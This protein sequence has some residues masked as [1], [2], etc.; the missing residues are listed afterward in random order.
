[1][2]L[3][4]TY[5]SI[6]HQM[7]STPILS[8]RSW[9]RQLV[10]IDI[11]IQILDI[12]LFLELLWYNF[13]LLILLICLCCWEI[14]GYIFRRVSQ[15]LFILNFSYIASGQMLYCQDMFSLF[16]FSSLW[17]HMKKKREEISVDSMSSEW[18]AVSQMCISCR[19]CCLFYDNLMAWKQF[20]IYIQ[21]NYCNTMFE[22]FLSTQWIWGSLHLTSPCE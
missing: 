21:F 11:N 6:F 10:I 8:L 15:R 20:L 19:F 7:N 12:L 18:I 9:L 4:Q 16:L 3:D 1:M 5:T 22:Q 13:C 2:F 17:N 14:F